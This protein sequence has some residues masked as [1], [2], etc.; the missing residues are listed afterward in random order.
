[1]ELRQLQHFL[2][3]V[4]TG[5]FHAAAAQVGLTQQAISR[6]IRNLEQEFGA[7]FLERKPRGGRRVTPTRF[8]EILLP[9]A[10]Q[11]TGEVQGFRIQMDNLMGSGHGLLRLAVAPSEIR[12]LLPRVI[13]TFRAR[14]PL[15]RIQIMRSWAPDIYERAASELYDVVLADEPETLVKGSLRVERLFGDRNVFV[16]APSHPLAAREAIELSELLDQQWLG[17][18]P[19]ARNRMQLNELLK[20]V[21]LVTSLHKL[22]TSSVDL[23]VRMLQTGGYVSFLPERL[24]SPELAEGSLVRLPVTH[25]RTPRWFHVMMQRA[26]V[27]PRPVV[28]AFMDVVRRVS[29]ELAPTPVAPGP[30]PSNSNK[31][32]STRVNAG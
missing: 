7:R 1:V 24:V 25:R 8:G 31:K 26:G 16:A 2:A 29:R 10:R 27:K 9:F 11:V 30:A 5:S 17:L 6:S 23:T 28:S 22:E 14:N 18:G 19:F 4:D 13:A 32:R 21:R 15:V 3:V 20:D 12:C